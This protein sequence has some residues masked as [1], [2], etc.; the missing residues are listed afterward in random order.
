MKKEALRLLLF[1]VICLGV[2]V[3]LRIYKVEPI[4]ERL[5]SILLSITAVLLVWLVSAIRTV[6]AV[7]SE[8]GHLK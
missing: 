2:F 5:P 1:V 7:L 4:M 8:H 6:R 3:G